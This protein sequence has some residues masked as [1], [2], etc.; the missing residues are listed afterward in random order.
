MCIRDRFNDLPSMRGNHDYIFG[1][2]KSVCYAFGAMLLVAA[3]R[4]YEEPVPPTV[5]KDWIFGEHPLICL[6]YTSRCV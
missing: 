6:L 5:V 2:L 4:T 3:C 1:F